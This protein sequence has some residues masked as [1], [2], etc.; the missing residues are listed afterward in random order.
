MKNQLKNTFLEECA[1]CNSDFKKLLSSAL[2][3][4]GT[5]V[6]FD[7]DKTEDGKNKFC[8][9]LIGTKNDI[10][11]YMFSDS[12]IHFDS[13][14]D[15]KKPYQI[16]EIADLLKGKEVGFRGGWRDMRIAK[17]SKN[18]LIDEKNNFILYY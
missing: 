2:A 5:Y 14:Y 1:K 4:K 15:K 18:G 9:R 17:V 13:L 12:F 11:T 7:R 6:L 10:L 3:D 8:V 16:W